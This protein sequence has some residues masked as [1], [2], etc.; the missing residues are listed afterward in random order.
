[1][2][3]VVNVVIISSFINIAACFN[4]KTSLVNKTISI[5]CKECHMSFLENNNTRSDRMEIEIL[6]DF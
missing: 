4:D 5:M 2:K 1:M 3:K 6:V